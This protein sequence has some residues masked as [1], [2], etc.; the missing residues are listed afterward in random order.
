MQDAQQYVIQEFN[1]AVLKWTK[2]FRVHQYSDSSAKGSLGFEFS[3]FSNTSMELIVYGFASLFCSEDQS[4][5]CS[6]IPLYSRG[7]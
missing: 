5:S 3:F 7:Q 6:Q 1:G 2:C 4:F